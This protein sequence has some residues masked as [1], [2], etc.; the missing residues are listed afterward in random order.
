LQH[1]R[2]WLLHRIPSLRFLD[3]QK[4]RSAER[5]QAA[6]LFGTAA[7][8]TE[9]ASKIM[10]V[11]SR[12]FDVS[13]AAANGPQGGKVQRTKLTEKE[14]RR[15]EEM[16]RNARSLGEISRLEKELSEGR[17]PGGVVGGGDEMEE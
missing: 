9:L 3:F 15:V 1:Y 7:E 5:S 16:I 13:A 14:R 4:V 10:G 17:V 12:T 8:P 6:S 11:K 2:H